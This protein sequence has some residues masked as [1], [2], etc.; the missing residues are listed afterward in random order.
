[1]ALTDAKIRNTKPDAARRIRLHDAGGLYLE[2]SPSATKDS[3]RWWRLKYRIGGA[4]KRVSLGVYPAVSLKAARDAR[5]ATRQQ[6]RAGTDPAAAKRGDTFEAVARDWHSKQN[7]A[8]ADSHGG[9]ILR[10]LERDVFPWLGSRP[11]AG[12]KA[13]EILAVL[14]RVE[15]RG[16]V[17]TAR[18]ILQYIGNVMRYAMARG[19]LQADPTP[20]LR[21]AL[22]TPVS[23][24]LPSIR[25]PK[26]LGAL[27]RD[28]DAYSGQ[29]VTRCALRL[30]PLLFVRPGELRHMEWSEVDEAAAEWRI[31]ATK[32]KL[33]R[34][35]IVPLSRQAL[36]ILDELRPLT[37]ADD[38]SRYVFPGLRSAGRPMSEN[39]VNAALRR[40]GYAKDEMVGHGFRSI[41]STMLNES[42]QFTVDAIERQLSHVERSKVRAAYNHAEH[43][44]ERRRLMQWWADHLDQLKSC[45]APQE[46]NDRPHDPKVAAIK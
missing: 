16:A 1:M 15:E 35:H 10:R 36:T 31:P 27:L 30:A 2:I 34:E 33:R 40:L 37:G 25:E 46:R 39:T 6:V 21:G 3:G 8:W 29:F 28:L 41:A 5:D 14:E 17:E 44:P 19:L 11:I 42:H 13:P 22:A 4:E 7:A 38:K 24:N 45:S 32:M 9:R 18:R 26:A 43:L 23:R 20:A 12:L